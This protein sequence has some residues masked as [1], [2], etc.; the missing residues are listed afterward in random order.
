[1]GPVGVDV[2]SQRV[3]DPESERTAKLGKC[4]VGQTLSQAGSASLEPSEEELGINDALPVRSEGVPLWAC[5]DEQTV[6][7]TAAK[8]GNKH[9]QVGGRVSRRSI[10]P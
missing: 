6:A 5:D 4:S 1:L 8:A 2:F 7:Q 9:F 10:A 3:T